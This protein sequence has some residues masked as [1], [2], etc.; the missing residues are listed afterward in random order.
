MKKKQSSIDWLFDRLKFIDKNAYNELYDDYETVS[1]MHQSEVEEA[2]YDGFLQEDWTWTL[3]GTQRVEEPARE[4]YEKTYG[5]VSVNTTTEIPGVD[6]NSVIPS[7]P[8]T[9]RENRNK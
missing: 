5:S 7:E 9:I 6:R 8:Q 4:Y 1:S 2:W 3:S